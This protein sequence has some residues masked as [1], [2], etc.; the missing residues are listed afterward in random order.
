MKIAIIA[1]PW[2]PVPPTQYGGIETVIHNLVEGLTELGEEVL[3]FALKDSKVSCKLYPYLEAYFR[4]GM[5]SPPDQKAFVREL[6]LKYAY[7]RA[8]YEKVDIIHDHSLFN[9]PVNVPTLHTLYST[10]CEGSIKQLAELST[11]PKNHFVA[12]SNKQKERYLTL[13]R[14]FD[15]VDVIYHGINVKAIEWSS[16]KEDYFLCVGRASSEKGLDVVARVATKARIGLIMAIKMVEEEEKQFFKN[17][18]QPW[19]D[20]HPKDLFLQIFHEV[21]RPT[22]FDLFK[23]AKC[24]LFT[25]QWEQPFGTVMIESM[26]C[27]T[28]VIALRRGAASEIIVNG[29]T[30][31]VVNSEEEMI[32][33]IKKIDQIDPADCRRHAEKNFSRERMVKNYLDNYK[34]ILDGR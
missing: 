10:A 3:F 11:K 13:H 20:K 32:E 23:R 25:S 12:I 7:A 14:E 9:S 8:G 31:F 34:K 15:L 27:G 22:L 24:T 30:G 2:I 5:D 26:A 21:P 16:K 1:P 4:F 29:K 28:P 19:I 33:A 18:I 6:A 17:E